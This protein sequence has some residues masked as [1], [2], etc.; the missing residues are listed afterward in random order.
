MGSRE[1]CLGV[2]EN[3]RRACTERVH[4]IRLRITRASDLCC[5]SRED[6]R[7]EGVRGIP[8]VENIGATCKERS[9]TNKDQV[10]A[11]GS[12]AVVEFA[13]RSVFTDDDFDL[14][15]PTGQGTRVRID[16]RV[17]RRDDRNFVVQ[18]TQRL[19]QRGYALRDGS[20]L[21]VGSDFRSD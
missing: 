6:R 1:R 4:H 9:F 8:C 14:A 10:H 12:A 11:T 16:A 18:A 3:E 17:E 20:V 2:R 21:A 13:L 19:G 15:Q 5:S 7:C